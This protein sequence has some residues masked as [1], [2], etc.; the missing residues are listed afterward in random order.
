MALSVSVLGGVNLTNQPLLS[1]MGRYVHE[2]YVTKIRA[3]SAAGIAT[4]AAFANATDVNNHRAAVLAKMGDVFGPAFGPSPPARGAL[5]PVVLSSLTRTGYT[6]EKVVY[7]SE[8][9]LKVSG[10]LY[11]P[12]GAS[13]SSKVP[14]AVGMCGHVPSGKASDSY[15]TFGRSLALMGIACI[16]ID[17]LGQG[18]RKQYASNSTVTEHVILGRQMPLVGRTLA[19]QQAYDASRAVD[20]LYSRS[21]IDTAHIGAIGNS[22]GG[23]QCVWLT[24]L[25]SRITMSAPSCF[26]TE[27]RRNLENELWAD[28]EQTPNDILL[29]NFDLDDLLLLHAPKPMI[30]LGQELDYF[31]LRG[32]T[33]IYDRLLS[34]Y[35]L[36]GSPGNLAISVGPY[37][38]G[39]KIA[40]REAAYSFFNLHAF[41]GGAVTE[42]VRTN[43]T[44]ATLLCTSTGQVADEPG[45]LYMR[46]IMTAEAAAQATARG[47]PSG[48]TLIS[49]VESVLKMPSISRATPPDY[50]VLEFYQNHSSPNYPKRFGCAFQVETEAG[51]VVPL[52]RHYDVSSWHAPLRAVT[53]GTRAIVY[54]AHR[55]NDQEMVINQRPTPL[56]AALTAEPTAELFG[57]DMRMH[58]ETKPLYNADHAEDFYAQHARMCGE[59][60]LGKQVWDV[61]RCI[62]LIDSYGYSDIYLIGYWESAIQAALVA[63]LDTRCTTV[64]LFNALTRWEACAKALPNQM[65]WTT[66]RLPHGVLA[67]FD[68]PDVYAEL[69]SR[70]GAQFTNTAQFGAWLSNPG[71]F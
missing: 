60:L 57:I 35:T 8:P 44:E 13:P 1:R 53:P 51:I 36:L 27:F 65:A 28:H 63:L 67:E 25:D 3:A 50:R 11:L 38:H 20:Y 45:G 39:F 34:A 59:E 41:G 56:L 32:L 46:D 40:Q 37:D 10:N 21:D 43:D 14:G 19:G 31:D 69:T 52:Y 30:L 15:Q 29:N 47:T 26:T 33:A 2:Y 49:R 16:V 42:P 66:L 64:R 23:T 7:D 48:A 5:N 54:L 22:G 58:G 61:L 71:E 18:E 4:K 6:I 17:C 62:D 68:L 70:L 12:A 24:A 9:G 55:S